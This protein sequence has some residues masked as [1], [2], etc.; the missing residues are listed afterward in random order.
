MYEDCIN[1]GAKINCLIYMYNK[2]AFLLLRNKYTTTVLNIASF[3]DMTVVRHFCCICFVRECIL[4]N[5]T[6]HKNHIS[7]ILTSWKWFSRSARIICNCNHAFGTFFNWH[8]II[9]MV[10]IFAESVILGIIRIWWIIRKL[11][12]KK[13]NTTHENHVKSLWC[14]WY[15]DIFWFADLWTLA[16]T[17]MSTKFA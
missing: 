8:R 5:V 13:S 16:G 4:G 17:P 2:S 15:F 3:H 11:H 10:I 9:P 1:G 7:L 14:E 6:L 12:Y